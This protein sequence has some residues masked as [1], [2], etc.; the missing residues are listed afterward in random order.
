[1]QKILVLLFGFSFIVI[2][3]CSLGKQEDTTDTTNSITTTGET[4]SNG[5][6]PPTQDKEIEDFFDFIEETIEEEA[7]AAEQAE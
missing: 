6:V 2:T 4:E 3:G 1:M 7:K 5:I